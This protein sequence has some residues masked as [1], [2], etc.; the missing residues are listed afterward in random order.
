MVKPAIGAEWCY[1]LRFHDATAAKTRRRALQIGSRRSQQPYDERVENG[2]RRW[3]SSAASGPCVTKGPILPPQ[4]QLPEFDGSGTYAEDPAPADPGFRDVGRRLC[5]A[6]KAACTRLNIPT[7]DLLCAR[8]DLIGGPDN[9]C[10][11]NWRWS[12]RHSAGV[13]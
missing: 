13:S 9:H 6:L 8:V 1:P 5:T 10:F 7:T 3:C 11:S 12:N 2:R 4:N